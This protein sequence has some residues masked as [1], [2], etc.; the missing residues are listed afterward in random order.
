MVDITENRHQAEELRI[1]KEAAEAA[2]LAKSQFLAMMSHEIRTPMNGV[3]GMT[4]L[5]LDSPLSPSQKEYA[6]TIRNSGDSLLTIINDILDFSKIESGRFELEEGNFEVRECIEGAL[7][8][9]ATRAAEKQLDLLYDIA[10]GVPG[11]VIGDATRL[12]QIL[13]NLLGNALKFTEQGEVLLTV[14]S[15]AVSDA[16]IE[17]EFSIRDTGIGISQEG[18]DRLFKSFSQVD[19]SIA[20]RFGGTGLG[21]VISKRLAELMGGGMK[22]ESTVGQGSLFTFTIQA[23]PVASKPRSYMRGGKSQLAG[24][25][26]L[27]VDDNATNRRILSEWA[28]KWQMPVVAVDS[29]EAALEYFSSGE[30]VDV[31]ILDMQMPG[32]DGAT[33]A[34]KLKDDPATQ[35]LPLVLLSSL[36]P[37]EHAE[38]RS[39]FV[40][41]LTKPAKPD[42]LLEI[43]TTIFIGARP[44]VKPHLATEVKGDVVM[45][46]ERVLLAED[47]VVNQK[48]ALLMLNKLGF[49]ADVAANGYEVIDSLN[50]QK[51]D[52][53]LM[54]VQMPE[55]DGLEATRKIVADHPEA[56]SRPW[57]VALTANAMQGDRERCLE[58]GMDDYIS[59]PLKTEVLTKALSRAIDRSL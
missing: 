8:L 30:R 33:L 28:E 59:K 44:S 29:G 24:R 20:R 53:I 50:R 49:Q 12:R 34:R 35:D 9:M 25:R 32:M 23:E 4:S 48:V 40:E 43:L 52:I 31:A 56:S 10:D 21:L 45:H 14:R 11:M 19:T 57:I 38:S 15:Y 39:L 6:E 18:Q 17:L 16:R 41:C 36:G 27:L 1:A 42:R 58:A 55:M 47:N 26:L 7:D 51:Y 13:V 3:I 37:R 2:N 5:L 22:V 54:D 46:K